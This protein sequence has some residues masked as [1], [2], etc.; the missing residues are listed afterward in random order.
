MIEEKLEE[1]GFIIKRKLKPGL[2]RVPTEHRPHKRNGVVYVNPETIVYHSYDDSIESG[3]FYKNNTIYDN[4]TTEEK[5]AA[6]EKYIK[7]SQQIQEQLRIDGLAEVRKVF[8]KFNNSCKQHTYLTKKQVLADHKLRLDF[9]G[10]IA[11][12]AYNIDKELVGYQM[13]KEDGDKHWKTGSLPNGAF[14]P[15]TNNGLL[16]D[17]RIILLAEGYA[18]SA[19]INMAIG[20]KYIQTISCFSSQNVDKVADILHSK[21]DCAIFVVKDN[22]YAGRKIKTLGFT[23]GESDEDANDYMCKNGIE[24]LRQ[25]INEH[26]GTFIKLLTSER[27]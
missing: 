6:R 20:D 9:Y 18:T 8:N 25:K 27:G 7:E 16:T 17:A 1:L 22:D 23:V 4:M 10:N 24:A 3:Y 5:I 11:V 14:F 12:P 26:I 13:I 21:L 19:S 2:N 15:F